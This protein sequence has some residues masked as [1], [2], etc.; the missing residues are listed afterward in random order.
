MKT[1]YI[2]AF[3]LSF[4]LS[5]TP[6]HAAVKI[7]C[8]H[9]ELCRLAQIIFTENH[10]NN[11]EFESLVK[12]VGDPHEFEPTTTEVKDL[13]KANILISGPIELNPWIKK[14]NYQ[15]A[16]MMD[17]KT[18]NVPLDDKD[19][20]LYSSISHEPLSHFWLYPKIFCTIKSH[21]EEQFIKLK[22]LIVIPKN[23]TCAGEEAKIISELQSTL[24][25][26]KYP[27]VLT[28]DALLPLV[29]SLK[30]SNLVVAIKGSGHHSEASPQSVKKL[31]DALK[32]PKVIWII[33][34]KISVPQNILAKKRSTDLT[35]NL[36][37]ANSEGLDYFQVLKNLNEKLKALRP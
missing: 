35:V 15:R 18:I 30:T 8:S 17:I 23:K 26:L 22:Y 24:E 32:A 5:L 10:T 37:T 27:I 12:I 29:V 2:I 16:K 11:I 14:V 21:M 3:L 28:H 6:G 4:I 7:S 31:Y 34:E 25:S 20:S 19:Y 33:E 13:I 36:D 1:R 9:P